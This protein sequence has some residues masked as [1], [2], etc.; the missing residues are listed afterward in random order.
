[1]RIFITGAS[2][3]I[4]QHLV[5]LLVKDNHDLLILRRK[6]KPK[7]QIKSQAVTG[8]LRNLDKIKK[9]IIRFGPQVCIHLAWEGIPDFSYEQSKRN[10]DHSMNLIHM[11]IS[12]TACRKIIVSGSSWEYGKPRGVC[13]DEDKT[14]VTSFFT[15]AKNA[16][17]SGGS[18]LCS[19]RC[20]DFIWLRIF[21][22]FGP[23]QKK[24]TLIPTLYDAF[25]NGRKPDIKNP[26]NAEDFI[27]VTDV[28]QAFRLAV[29]KPIKSGVYNIGRQEPVSVSEIYR[30][31]E[32]QML[33]KLSGSMPK[34][35]KKRAAV[36][37]WA[38]TSKF[39]RS[40]G[41]SPRVTI[42]QGIKKHIAFLEV[43]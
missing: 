6:I 37:N 22:A 20:V 40:A 42:P 19:Q 11:L 30:I 36:R 32:K 2:G 33:H 4:G 7:G 13:R 43:A 1:M 14:V 25:K 29:K 39:R 31:V 35:S 24:Y 15:W 18:L 26:S 41:W 28:A 23:G 34:I 16:I 21:F 9:K 10:L 12:Q 5:P 38:E 3:F 27:Y 8:D 17:Y